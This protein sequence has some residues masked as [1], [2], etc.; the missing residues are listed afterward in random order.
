MQRLS[1]W[2]WGFPPKKYIP[3]E[4]PRDKKSAVYFSVLISE[5]EKYIAERQ[6][7]TKKVYHIPPS[8]ATRWR[9][10]AGMAVHPGAYISF[11]AVS[12][13]EENK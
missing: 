11:A 2:T 8:S 9:K 1:Q 13:A 5:T 4:Y 3:R 6:Q 7:T 12:S 10:K